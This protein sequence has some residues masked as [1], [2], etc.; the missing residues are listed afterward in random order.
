MSPM[1]RKAI[2][3]TV[4]LAATIF[5]ALMV[6]AQAPTLQE[7][8]AAQYKLVKMG[9][10]SSGYSVVEE[11]TLLD[12]QKGGVIGIAYKDTG[13]STNRYENGV[14]HPPSMVAQKGLG[15]LKKRFGQDEQTTK[16]F[17]KGD[18]VYPAKIDVNVEKDTVTMGIV[19]CDTC[20]KTDP[21]TYNKAQI[22]FQFS[23]G[24]LAKAG[25][26]EV[27]DTIGTLLAV[28]SDDQQPAKGGDQGGQQAAPEQAQQP[29][30][31]QPSAEPA[32]IEMGM[33]PAQ[34]EAALGKPDKKV[35]LGTKQ[36]YY[37]KDMKVTFKD[38]K[39][40]DVQ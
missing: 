26:G 14:I 33:T 17:A 6:S 36:M 10:D 23:K 27:E 39:V 20:N 19:A 8:L 32:S 30:A 1:F 12:V 34:V 13:L 21:T 5:S 31:A 28:S 24:A 11:G 40:A 9:S 2:A 16:L 22:V 38:G 37:Y 18:K 15:M 25:A 35:T 29:Q 4:I 3:G 7:Q